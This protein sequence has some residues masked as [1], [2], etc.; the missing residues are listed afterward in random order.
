MKFGYSSSIIEYDFYLTS[1][2]VFRMVTI[3][4][5]AS[6]FPE[7]VVTVVILEIKNKLSH[8]LVYFKFCFTK[9][10]WIKDFKYIFLFQS[11][12]QLVQKLALIVNNNG[13][14]LQYMG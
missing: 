12:H 4:H 2:W 7:L 1:F 8:I 10:L 3:S 9:D 14:S 11:T 6:R 5:T 13:W